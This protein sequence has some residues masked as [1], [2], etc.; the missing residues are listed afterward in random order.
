MIRTLEPA[1][2]SRRIAIIAPSAREVVRF[3]RDLITEAIALGH[4]V[5]VL[6]PC[7]TPAEGEALSALG[8]EWENCEPPRSAMP[9]LANWRYA[10]AIAREL[11]VW[12]ASAVLAS[13]HGLAPVAARAARRAGAGQI[14]TLVNDIADTEGAER[15]NRLA[16][17][18]GAFASSTGVVCHNADDRLAIERSQLLP[19]CAILTEVPGAGVPLDR[20]NSEPMPGFS[21]GPIFVMLDDGR[22][23]DVVDAF[24]G[25]ARRLLGNG[26][27]FRARLARGSDSGQAV[28]PGACDGVEL[29]DGLGEAKR[30][31]ADAHVLIHL[32]PDDGM[33]PVVLEALAMGRA[34]V[35][36]GLPGL[37]QTVDDCVNGCIVNR[38]GAAELA[39]AMGF[40]VDRP[41]LIETLGAASR[42]K[43][44]RAFDAR[45]AVGS[46]LQALGA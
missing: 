37:R 26:R 1:S 35:T 38:I 39:D 45:Q 24:A 31:I 10:A 44:A 20:C 41:E 42:A 33:P 14:V 32:V 7:P 29:V 6:T 9:F 30:A 5:L 22:H 21:A 25:A 8:V 36:A 17:Y 34:I 18:G 12:G 2:A 3:R 19:R 15:Q 46:V 11:K 43:A 16:A 4:K 27:H 23:L 13:G 40:L 28:A